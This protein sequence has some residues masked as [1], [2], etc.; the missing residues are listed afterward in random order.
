MRTGNLVA[1]R[2]AELPAKFAGGHLH[3]AAFYNRGALLKALYSQKKLNRPRKEMEFKSA[4]R[5]R[6]G[7]KTRSVRMLTYA[8]P[9][10]I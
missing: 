3:R 10:R 9:V 8:I 2:D 7:V 6:W 1:E 4:A 5:G